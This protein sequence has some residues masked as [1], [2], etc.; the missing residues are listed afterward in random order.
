MIFKN[1]VTLLDIS[2]LTIGNKNKILIVF[3]NN[4]LSTDQRVGSILPSFFRNEVLEIFFSDHSNLVIPFI[5]FCDTITV[6]RKHISHSTPVVVASTRGPTDIDH[7]AISILVHLVRNI[8]Y[9]LSIF[10]H[11]KETLILL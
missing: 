6:E 3:L 5:V 2:N 8:F 1:L 10:I 4:L 11:L 7:D 9:K